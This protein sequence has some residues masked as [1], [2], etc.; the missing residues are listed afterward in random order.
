MF[1]TLGQAFGVAN[2]PGSTRSYLKVNQ[3]HYW[4]DDPQ[5]SY[6]NQLVDITQTGKQWNSAEHL[7]NYSKAYKYAIAV[8]FNTSH[9]SGEGSAIFLHCATGSTTAGCISIDEAHMIYTLQHL[10]G[11]TRIIIDQSGNIQNY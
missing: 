2:N 9:I 6:Y 11:D 8:N 4:I 3:N 10:N 7:I 5:S 1:Y